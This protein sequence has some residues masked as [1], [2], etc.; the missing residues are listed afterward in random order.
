MEKYCLI[1]METWK[2]QMETLKR[3]WSRFLIDTQD[4]RVN[5]MDQRANEEPPWMNPGR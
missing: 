4:H 2:D 1:N 5:S 3:N